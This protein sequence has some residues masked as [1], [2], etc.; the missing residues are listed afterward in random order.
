MP[1]D[2]VLRES[3]AEQFAIEFH[4]SGRGKARC[5][6]DPAYPHGIA[7]DGAGNAS[8]WCI[9]RLPY[10]APECGHFRVD[11]KLCGFSLL[12][13]AAGRAD[14]PISVRMPCSEQK[15]RAPGDN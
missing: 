10:P 12:I 1:E 9:A 4:A 11:C 2:E 15:P 8:A 6:P 14:D 3:Q 7:I 13:T 5:D